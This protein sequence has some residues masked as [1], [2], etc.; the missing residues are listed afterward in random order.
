MSHWFLTSIQK[1]YFS[2]KARNMSGFFAYHS[3]SHFTLAGSAI[4]SLDHVY[5]NQ[6]G[7]FDN[8]ASAYTA[9]VSGVYAFFLTIRLVK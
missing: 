7:D 1:F 4:L 3:A 5:S 9:P 2:E 6:G 8:I